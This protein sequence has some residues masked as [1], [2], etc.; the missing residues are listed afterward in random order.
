VGRGSIRAAIIALL[1]ERPMHGYQ[2]MHELATRTSG[3]WRPS[4]GSIYPTLQR[5]EDECLIERLNDRGKRRYALTDAGRAEA[6]QTSDLQPPWDKIA[7][8][9]PDAQWIRLQR[10]MVLLDGTLTLLGETG[11]EDQKTKAGDV[12]ADAQRRLFGILAED[13]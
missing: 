6:L 1:A 7:R 13:D 11:S 9:E 8:A 10:L 4:P 2:M 3:N 12:L 5:L